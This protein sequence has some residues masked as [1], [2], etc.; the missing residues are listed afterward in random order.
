MKQLCVCFS[1]WKHKGAVPT[2]E[3]C[4]TRD[5][6]VSLRLVFADSRSGL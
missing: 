2:Q 4:S 6:Q 1:N 3:T 5:I